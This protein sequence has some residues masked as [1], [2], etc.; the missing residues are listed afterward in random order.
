MA[1]PLASL[2]R[3]VRR[4]K[5]NHDADADLVERFA[6]RGDE[7]AFS[8]LVRR[9][10]S[11]V[12]GVCRRILDD[13]HRAEDAAQAV[14]LVLARKAGSLRDRTAVA[15]WLYGVAVR[16]ARKARGR[17]TPAPAQLPDDVAAVER[18]P[19]VIWSELRPVLDREVERLPARHRA[20]VVLCYLEGKSYAEAARELRCP[21]GT[22][23][24]RLSRARARLRSRLVRQGV[25]LSAAALSSIL[26]Q[27]AT[28]AGLGVFDPLSPGATGPAVALSKGVLQAMFLNKL[29]TVALV[30]FAPAL[31]GVAGLAYRSFAAGP[32]DDTPPPAPV[33]VKQQA[34]RR[35]TV[36]PKVV[37]P[38]PPNAGVS[39]PL[40]KPLRI[41]TFYT[42]VFEG[43]AV[44]Q[45]VP[46]T[47]EIPANIPESIQKQMLEMAER[48]SRTSPT[49]RASPAEPTPEVMLKRILSGLELL[50]QR[51]SALERK[52]DERT[53]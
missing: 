26:V 11:M 8:L 18:T 34:D 28:A 27:K 22:V 33:V 7:H 23:A 14:F 48:L 51:M 42:P 50:E 37:P 41:T 9:H 38:V 12:L 13:H 3:H 20:A 45:P 21:V 16:T 4:L 32:E 25:T 29:K 5:T 36:P 49:R 30:M 43:G 10:G 24:T 35:P 53:P 17:Q 15:N 19:D 2:L 47:M 44:G 40:T 39:F 1:A 52:L 31:L 46:Y 6:A